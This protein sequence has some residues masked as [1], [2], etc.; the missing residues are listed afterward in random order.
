MY[1]AVCD[2]RQLNETRRWHSD[3]ERR[4]RQGRRKR[5]KRRIAIR[6]LAAVTVTTLLGPPSCKKFFVP[7]CV[8]SSRRAGDASGISCAFMPTA[9]PS[10]APGRRP[11]HPH[12]R[13]RRPWPQR[14]PPRPSPQAPPAL[15]YV[16]I[17]QTPRSA[18]TPAVDSLHATYQSVATSVAPDCTP[19]A[20]PLTAA[21]QR[22]L[23]S[24]KF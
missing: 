23:A 4:E 16:S 24:A 3:C 2:L 22:R 18:S 15:K 17:C 14:I 9:N 5:Y 8:A 13:P 11:R 1:A 20:A 6:A 19:L 10:C 12:R 7:S 21:R